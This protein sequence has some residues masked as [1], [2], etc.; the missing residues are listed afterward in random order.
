MPR[1]TAVAVSR[2]W[3]ISYDSKTVVGSRVCNRMFRKSFKEIRKGSYQ[4][5]HVLACC[6]LMHGIEAAVHWC[7]GG[8]SLVTLPTAVAEIKP[9][10]YLARAKFNR[11][12]DIP[13]DDRGP[14]TP[15]ASLTHLRWLGARDE[16]IMMAESPQCIK[17]FGKNKHNHL[18]QMLSCGCNSSEVEELA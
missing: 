8:S 15:I 1:S 11:M 10:V 14:E 6:E 3:G 18:M 9:G 2:R 13:K 5:I 7:A 17:A 16:F 12:K 4:V